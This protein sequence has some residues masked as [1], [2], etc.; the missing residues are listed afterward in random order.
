MI[1][2][3]TDRLGIN[4]PTTVVGNSDTQT[5][6]LLAIANEEGQELAGRGRWPGLIRTNSFTLSLAANQGALNGTVISDADYDYMIPDTFW[7]STTSLPITGSLDSV[8]WRTLQAFPV[9]GPYQQF[10]IRDGNDLY[11]DPVPTSAD[12]AA[13]DYYSTAWCE[14]SDGTAR[15]DG[16]WGAD[17][18]VGRLPERVMA[19]GI[20][21][22]WKKEKGLDY[23]QDFETYEAAVADALSRA[24]SKEVLSLEGGKDKFRQHGI[25]I[26]IGNW[27]V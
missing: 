6:Q 5:R 20:R 22:R 18:D 24:S 15:S 2:S 12:T 7:N 4:R 14:E 23:G 8:D 19:L 25:V 21:W 11:I 3:V 16:E 26:P 17:T 10:M 1:Q 27:N 13:F 9:T